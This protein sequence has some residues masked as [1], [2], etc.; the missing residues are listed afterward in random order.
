MRPSMS[1]DWPNSAASEFH[2]TADI[3]WHVQVMGQ[4]PE[5]LLL[6]GTGASVH[7]W[8]ELA[9]LL[10]TRFRVIAPDLPGHGLSSSPAFDRFSLPAMARALH[11]LLTRL[12][13]APRVAAGH[14]AGA[15]ILIRMTLSGY[16]RPRVLVS[17]NGALVPFEGFPRWLFSPLAKVLAR[18][19]WVPRLVARRAANPAAIRRL[20]EDTGSKL[21]AS[22]IEHYQRVVQRPSH[23]AAAL[24]MMANWDLDALAGELPLLR[25]P[26]KLLVADGDRTVPP[27]DA[28][29]VQALLPQAE[30]IS[31]GGLGHLAHEEQPA[32][33]AEQIV[34]AATAAG[35]F[36]EMPT[37]SQAAAPASFQTGNNPQW[38]LP[39]M[40]L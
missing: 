30:I 1:G 37:G 29:R 21:D 24:A 32:A 28:R 33:V 35:A 36:A 38:L 3:R 7:S 39:S 23:V 13:V 16:I 34:R 26:L 17:V 14:S 19:H 8:R 6:H 5:L 27:A 20:I 9:P 12:Q 40:Q 2:D 31:L 25:T 10:A 11:E 18:S 4:G 22:G 15:A